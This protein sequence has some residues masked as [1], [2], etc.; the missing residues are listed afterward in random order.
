[1]N[2]LKWI[3][4]ILLF[5]L[6]GCTS[7]NPYA[8]EQEMLNCFYEFKRNKESVDAKKNLQKAEEAFLKY[9]LLA[10][11]SAKSYHQFIKRMRNGYDLNCDTLP[12]LR[13]ILDSIQQFIPN[14]NCPDSVFV[15]KDSTQLFAS[16]IYAI[17]KPL[18]IFTQKRPNTTSQTRV[19][20]LLKSFTL[21]DLK[22]E[23][24]KKFAIAILAFLIQDPDETQKEYEFGTYRLDTSRIEKGRK[25]FVIQVNPK[26]KIRAQMKPIKVNQLKPAIVQFLLNAKI[27]SPI[28]KDSLNLKALV[29]SLH[30]K[31]SFN[32]DEIILK[33]R[34]QIDLA[35]Q[36]IKDIYS[37]KL[38]QKSAK[39]LDQR[40]RKIIDKMLD[41]EIYEEIE[42]P[43]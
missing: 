12:G 14:V 39:Q 25:V 20:E 2:K 6:S 10:D 40:Q 23:Y 37:R 41:L 18:K 26:G 34:K 9:R 17:I 38:F 24:Y 16:R 8:L 31:D 5:G 11:S 15:I 43:I 28:K 13:A 21:N 4:I 32:D 19:F 36:E 29:Y 42:E 35:F 27:K 22:Q 1:M 7:Q 3:T 33:I 30:H